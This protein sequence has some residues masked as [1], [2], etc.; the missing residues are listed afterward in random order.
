MTRF[1]HGLVAALFL[2]FLAAAGCASQEEVRS[3]AGQTSLNTAVL[4]VSIFDMAQSSRRIAELR[5]ANMARLQAET[6]A[7]KSRT[8]FDLALFEQIDESAVATRLEAL[9]TWSDK[10]AQ[11]DAQAAV[12][13]TAFIVQMLEGRREL[14]VPSEELKAVAKILAR[15]AAEED[16]AARARFLFN[17]VKTVAVEVKAQREAA[18][19]A[20]KDA[21]K[22][23]AERGAAGEG[24]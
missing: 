23:L 1:R 9:K 15:L 5:A 10:V 20:A 2:T 13:E 3:L 18:K 16:Q 14:E 4:G 22:A 7:V 8:A 24:S 17:Y 19:Q 12:D 21:E 11:I 6:S